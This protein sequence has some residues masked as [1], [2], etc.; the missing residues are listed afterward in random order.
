MILS[1]AERKQIERGE[2]RDIRQL[3]VQRQPEP[4]PGYSDP[5]VRRLLDVAEDNRNL[6]DG[7]KASHKD[8]RRIKAMLG[9]SILLTLSSFAGGGVTGYKAYQSLSKDISHIEDK[10]PADEFNDNQLEQIQQAVSEVITSSETEKTQTKTEKKTVSDKPT[11]QQTEKPAE[12]KSETT[13][14]TPEQQPVESEV[15]Q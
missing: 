1:E 15:N 9:L 14:E 6:K 12:E 3:E 8:R 4:Y 10:L 2:L 7:I 13:T 5:Y 11:E